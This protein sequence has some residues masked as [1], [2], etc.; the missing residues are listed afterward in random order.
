MIE[1]RRDLAWED[2]FVVNEQIIL[3][4]LLFATDNAAYTDLVIQV[5]IPYRDEIGILDLSPHEVR[6][7]RVDELVWGY[8]VNIA[9]F[10]QGLSTYPFLIKTTD[11][12]APNLTT[13][14]TLDYDRT[15]HVV[16]A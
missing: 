6:Y 5:P 1:I 4:M 13:I 16:G 2:V 3:P 11:L 8:E 10:G 7:K 9:S 14:L 15:Y 12:V